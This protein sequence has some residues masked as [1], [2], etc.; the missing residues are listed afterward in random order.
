VGEVYDDEKLGGQ[1]V[2]ALRDIHM[3]TSK[4]KEAQRDVAASISVVATDLH[5][6]GPEHVL[7]KDGSREVDP[8]YLVY[9]IEGSICNVISNK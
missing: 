7:S 8:T 9:G 5:R 2:R 4:A 1:I 3:P 6:A